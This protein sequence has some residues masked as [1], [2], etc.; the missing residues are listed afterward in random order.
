MSEYLSDAIFLCR[1]LT[2]E[3]DVQRLFFNVRDNDIIRHHMSESLGTEVPKKK[4][5]K[6]KEEEK[7]ESAPKEK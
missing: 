4:K 1:L 2:V 6:K 7:T 5:K 3:K